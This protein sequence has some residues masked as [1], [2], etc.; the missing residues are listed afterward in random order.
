M[1]AQRA[2]TLLPCGLDG[3]T[4]LCFG[5][6]EQQYAVARRPDPLTMIAALMPSEATVLMTVLRAP[7]EVAVG[8]QNVVD[9]RVHDAELA[10]VQRYL[11]ASLEMDA[12]GPTLPQAS[13]KPAP[14]AWRSR[15]TWEL[16]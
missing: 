13:K 10:S 1:M 11:L 15:L 9:V 8:V 6:G 3:A 14:H 4:V 2:R 5:F 16:A 7:A 12:A